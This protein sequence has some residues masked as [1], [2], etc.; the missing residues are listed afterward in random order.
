MAGRQRDNLIALASEKDIGIDEE[1]TGPF[2]NEGREDR[3]EIGFS[4]RPRDKNLSPDRTSCLLH[5]GRV[6]LRVRIVRIYQQGDDPGRGH[7]F[8]QKPK[9]LR[10]QWAGNHV[11]ASKVAAWAL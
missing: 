2:L 9:L 10:R 3:L 8:V 1:R 4:D 6:A 7:H 5:D 11:D